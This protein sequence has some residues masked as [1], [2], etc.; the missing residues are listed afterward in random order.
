M[1]GRRGPTPIDVPPRPELTAKQ[2]DTLLRL[3]S[4]VLNF[5]DAVAPT[6]HTGLNMGMLR[7]LERKALVGW[8]RLSVNSQGVYVTHAGHTAANDILAAR[9]AA[10]DATA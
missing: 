7:A 9:E 5:R 6:R 2:A 10:E 8:H 3:R 4:I 1:T